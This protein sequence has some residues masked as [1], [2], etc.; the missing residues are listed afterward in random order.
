MNAQQL[1]A[2]LHARGLID[3]REVFSTWSCQSAISPIQGIH[4]IRGLVAVTLNGKT[5]SFY[6]TNFSNEIKQLVFS[7]DLD[8]LT[9]VKVNSFVL[10]PSMSFTCL[11]GSFKFLATNVKIFVPYFK[12]A[13]LIK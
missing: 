13:G 3:H 4:G 1:I 12:E 11:A 10:S 5:L 6:D 8:T 7:A 9:Q 2:D